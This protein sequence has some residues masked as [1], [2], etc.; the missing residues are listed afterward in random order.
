MAWASEHT[1]YCRN[2]YTDSSASIV[3]RGEETGVTV[4]PSRA[5]PRTELECL[6]LSCVLALGG[7]IQLHC[8]VQCVDKKITDTVRDVYEQHR[9]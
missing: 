3:T 9:T 8:R 5:M 2:S 7:R 6:G 1:H 4:R